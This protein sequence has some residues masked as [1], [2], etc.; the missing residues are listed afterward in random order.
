MILIIGGSGMLGRSMVVALSGTGAP[1]PICMA[2][3]HSDLDIM[4][5]V[6]VW[7]YIKQ[8]SPSAIINCAAMTDV[9]ACESDPQKAIKINGYA[10]KYISQA[11]KRFHS[12]FIQVSTDYVFDGT[13]FPVT[14][15]DDV[16][17]IQTYGRTKL[18]GEGFALEDG[19]I[20]ARVQ[21]LFGRNKQNFVSWVIGNIQQNH[22]MQISTDQIGSPSSTDWIARTLLM[23]S[24]H[25]K[26][27]GGSIYNVTH[28]DYGSRYE[29]AVCA[30]QSLGVSNVD[31]FLI[32]T[33]GA[34]FG[35]AQRPIKVVLDSSKLRRDL[36]IPSLGSWKNDVNSFVI[37]NW[38]LK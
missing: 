35:S 20:V 24:S 21:W 26:I 8:L 19:G 12:K 15:T 7:K 23:M 2:P 17:P 33:P 13:K 31:S 34:K 6:A 4:N 11:A 36:E 38:K 32:P 9:D 25:P 5:E 29:C 27:K 37:N 14:E 18:I 28:D 16:N 1:A 10:V 30:V 3:S 22:A